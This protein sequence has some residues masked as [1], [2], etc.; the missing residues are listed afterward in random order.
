MRLR[1]GISLEKLEQFGYHYQENLIFPTYRKVIQSGRR[2]I[3][4]EI[5]VADRTIFINRR[6][7]EFVRDGIYFLKDLELSNFL[8]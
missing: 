8:E 5:L 3:I 4:I 1:K 6:K 2:K 7:V